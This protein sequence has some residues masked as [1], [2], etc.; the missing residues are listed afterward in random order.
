M[1]PPAARDGGRE[2]GTGHFEGN[3][4]S[5]PGG[6]L[7][8]VNSRRLLTE[9]HRVASILSTT[10]LHGALREH[11]PK[12]IVGAVVSVLGREGCRGDPGE[13]IDD[14]VT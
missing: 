8:S 12:L 10:V 7:A 3:F 4:L 6:R 11:D 9:P 14:L 5:G 2:H 1:R 13:F